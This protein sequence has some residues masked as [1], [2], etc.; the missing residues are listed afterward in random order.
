MMA[1]GAL[2]AIGE[3]GL[4]VPRDIALVGFD[5]ITLAAY[6]IPPLTTVAQPTYEMGRLAGELLIQRIQERGRPPARHLLPVRLV[7]RQSA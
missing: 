7:V 1:I 6:V 3:A 4:A 5:D 2:R